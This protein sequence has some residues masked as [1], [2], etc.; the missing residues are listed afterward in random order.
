[1][2]DASGV[3]PKKRVSSKSKAAKAAADGCIVVEA[4]E[5]DGASGKKSA[6]F[7]LDFSLMMWGFSQKT[8]LAGALT[9]AYPC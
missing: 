9:L 6:L 1:V 8:Q 3:T 7:D 5:D 4:L 2:L